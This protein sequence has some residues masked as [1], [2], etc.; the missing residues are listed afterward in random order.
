MIAVVVT[1]AANGSILATELVETTTVRYRSGG[2]PVT[3]HQLIL[4]TACSA[5]CLIVI[6]TT[7]AVIATHRYYNT[8]LIVC[9]LLI[10]SLNL[11]LGLYRLYK[12]FCA[13]NGAKA[14][15]LRLPFSPSIGPIPTSFEGETGK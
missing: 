5:A 7:L 1:V 4:I 2:S 11:G 14:K 9:I 3:L 12:L 6:I 13:R 10:L 8:F 15:L